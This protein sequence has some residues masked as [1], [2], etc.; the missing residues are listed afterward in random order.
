M[1]AWFLY[2]VG[3]AVLYGAHQIFTKHLFPHACHAKRL[4]T[5]YVVSYMVKGLKI[6][7]ESFALLNAPSFGRENP[8][9]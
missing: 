2:A 6:S 4:E 7:F 9:C 1:N 3:A 5:P 8:L